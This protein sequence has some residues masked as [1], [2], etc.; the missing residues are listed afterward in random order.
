[1]Q[2]VVGEAPRT[3]AVCLKEAVAVVVVGQQ[4]EGEAPP[5]PVRAVVVW[6][7]RKAALLGEERRE[8]RP[9]HGLRP[10]LLSMARA[11]RAGVVVVSPFCCLPRPQPPHPHPPLPLWHRHRAGLARAAVWQR[12]AAGR[13]C[14]GLVLPRVPP[15]GATQHP[16]LPLA[17]PTHT[18][19]MLHSSSR[20]HS[21]SPGHSLLLGSCRARG[22]GGR[23][24]SWS[25]LAYRGRG[26]G[27][28]SWYGPKPW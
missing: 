10:L 17:R 26:R 24:P 11:A 3:V 4:H 19:P 15:R 27:R 14:R 7:A 16:P 13:L 9:R 6:A 8:H 20:R 23:A 5:P 21:S 18:P 1:M 22:R 28:G 25:C 2:E 12:A